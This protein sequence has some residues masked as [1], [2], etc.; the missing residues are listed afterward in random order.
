[1]IKNQSCVKLHF[2]KF[3]ASALPRTLKFFAN[4][5]FY[6]DLSPLKI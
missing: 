2:I 1:M 4:C 6:W 3:L 5:L